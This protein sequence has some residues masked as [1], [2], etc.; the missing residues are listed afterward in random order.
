MNNK[1]AIEVLR[2]M[3]GKL[4]SNQPYEKV[5]E[6]SQALQRAIECMENEGWISVNDKL[7]KQH[8]TVLT[9]GHPNDEGVGITIC[10]H[11]DGIFR[12]WES[13]KENKHTITH[14]RNLPKPPKE[15]E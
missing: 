9:Y 12:F 15:D 7:P 3:E 14:W 10:T 13:E 11:S 6:R 2:R 4:V 8:D 5:K 1:K